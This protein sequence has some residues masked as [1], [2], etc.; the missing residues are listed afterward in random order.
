[1]PIMLNGAMNG[2]KVMVF[3]CSEIFISENILK[4]L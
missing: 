4:N 1:M 3:I 2:K